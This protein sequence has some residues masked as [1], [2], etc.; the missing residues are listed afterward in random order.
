MQGYD[1]LYQY[2][3]KSRGAPR[4]RKRKQMFTL[5]ESPRLSKSARFSH[6]IELN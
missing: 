5:R 3:I 6:P 2:A 4:V 1:L